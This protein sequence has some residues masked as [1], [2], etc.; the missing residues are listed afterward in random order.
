MY[1]HTYIHVLYM[2]MY[3]LREHV[4]MNREKCTFIH[5]QAYICN[6]GQISQARRKAPAM[7]RFILPV[8]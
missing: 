3:V 8:Y 6:V 4:S 5:T 7:Y 1:T 2:C